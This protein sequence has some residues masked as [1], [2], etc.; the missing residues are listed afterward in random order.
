MSHFL[1]KRKNESKQMK[2]FISLTI[3]ISAIVTK[4][5]AGE[6]SDE[7]FLHPNFKVFDSENEPK[8]EIKIKKK[9][10]RQSKRKQNNQH[11]LDDSE[12]QR[13]IQRRDEKTQEDFTQK[14]TEKSNDRRVLNSERSQETPQ[15]R[16]QNNSQERGQ[17]E[18]NQ[19]E[20]FNGRDPTNDS[21]Q[22]IQKPLGESAG[23]KTQNNS[24]N[25]S[26]SKQ[27]A[28]LPSN[29]SANATKYSQTPR[30][31]FSLLDDESPEEKRKDENSTE[32]KKQF[33][34]LREM[35][36]QNKEKLNQKGEYF[37]KFLDSVK[38][39]RN[40]SSW[41]EQKTEKA[42]GNTTGNTAENNL[43]GEEKTNEKEQENKSAVLPLS[44]YHSP[45]STSLFT[46]PETVESLK[47]QIDQ[48]IKEVSELTAKLSDLKKK[49]EKGP[50]DRIDYKIIEVTDK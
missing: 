11:G 7:V 13:K 17:Q 3:F 42:T 5:G 22:M 4:V 2:S 24:V 45:L 28:G 21:D 37:D 25:S 27:L 33:E 20:K 12:P 44:T 16:N 35:N 19:Q 14:T 31:S 48:K 41:P 32:N 29:Y 36:G 23:K 39:E 34:P 43:N 46:S 8:Q 50:E 9:K 30:R 18:R 47:K 49:N 15:R 10:H 26:E 1:Q 40:E 38:G 6:R